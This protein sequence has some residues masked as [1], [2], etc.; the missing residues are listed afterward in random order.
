MAPV[1]SA[2]DLVE[3][4]HVRETGM[5]T[6]VNDDVLGPVLQHNVMWR[7]SETPG[8][9]RFTGRALGAD[10][11]DVLGELGVTAAELAALR[12]REVIAMSTPT[13]RLLLDAAA[14]WSPGPSTSAGR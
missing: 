6:E 13:T 10:T 7:M 9:I 4:P 14:A 12:A 1:Y 5:L 3:D 8:S 2:R 11:D